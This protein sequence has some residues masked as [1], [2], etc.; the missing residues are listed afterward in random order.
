MSGNLNIPPQEW[1]EKLF[2]FEYC[3]ECG[4]D[5]EHHTALHFMGNWFGR[6][7][8]PLDKDGNFHPVIKK[9]RKLQITVDKLSFVE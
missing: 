8:Y 5:A 2:E 7:D 6:C 4:G 3:D 1:L 9:F